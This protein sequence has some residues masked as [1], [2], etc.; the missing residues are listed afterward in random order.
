MQ[1]E[2]ID[3]LLTCDENGVGCFRIH[4]ECSELDDRGGIRCG[5][6]RGS[7]SNTVADS[8]KPMKTELVECQ[9]VLH[10]RD[11]M[12]LAVQPHAAECE[13]HLRPFYRPVR[14]ANVGNAAFFSA[15]R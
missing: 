10:Q 5:D 13:W 14:T 6:E 2:Q 7:Q 4:S 1:Q 11:A 8:C 3:A 9:Q 15:L 12:M